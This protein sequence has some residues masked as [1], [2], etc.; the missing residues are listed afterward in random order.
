MAAADYFL[1]IEGIKGES[2]SDKH[3]DE[4]DVESFSW[5]LTQT[6]T[7]AFGGGAGA[8]KANFQDFKFTMRV[9]RASPTLFL[10]CASGQHIKQAVMVGEMTS[11]IESASSSSQFLKYT[12]TDVII[13]SY[14]DGG[15]DN[16]VID[17]AAL[18]YADVKV[19]AAPGAVI[20]V[21]PDATGNLMFDRKTGQVVVTESSAGLV[22]SG[23]TL[24]REGGGG[25]FSRGVIEYALT[26]LVGII[27]GPGPCA[28]MLDVREVRQPSEITGGQPPEDVDE[29]RATPPDTFP[30]RGPVKKLS[31]HDVYWYG[32]A[33]L[34][35]TAEDFSRRARL[36][37]SIQVDPSSPPAEMSFDLC[38]I[39]RQNGLANI[40]IRIQSAMDHTSLMEEE[41]GIDPPEPDFLDDGT[42]FTITPAMFLVDLSLE[43]N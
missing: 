15:S 8:G 40:G 22:T 10:D 26:D 25:G 38:E 23:P 11:D 9:N 1:K 21:R 24:G 19:E 39:V 17:A 32:P 2:T 12:F 27:T 18:K 13:S 43:L 3:K 28:L 41:G 6:G 7:F 5:G 4:I 16:G 36:L 35:L 42:P 14:Q 20:D 30:G 29:V 37:G 31:R 33:D 34:E